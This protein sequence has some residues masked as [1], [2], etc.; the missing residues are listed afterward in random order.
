MQLVR[1]DDP[2]CDFIVSEA[3]RIDFT[4]GSVTVSFP[5][6]RVSLRLAVRHEGNRVGEIGF[7]GRSVTF[8]GEPIGQLHTPSNGSD[9]AALRIE[10]NARATTAAVETLIDNLIVAGPP[11]GTLAFRTA[12]VTLADRHGRITTAPV[13]LQPAPKPLKRSGSSGGPVG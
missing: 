5:G 12:L 6:P 7:D 8:S 4:G 9:G 13:A 1:D 10:L 3:D 2:A 11:S